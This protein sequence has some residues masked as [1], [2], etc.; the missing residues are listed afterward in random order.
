VQIAAH[1]QAQR[2]I[3][4]REWFIEEED[5]R[6]PEE[7]P[8]KDDSLLLPPGQ[9]GWQAVEEIFEVQQPHNFVQIDRCD[10]PAPGEYEVVP[11]PEMGIQ[12]WPLED[13][14][15]IP[16]VW[17]Q[18][19]HIAAVNADAPGCGCFEPGDESQGRRLAAAGGA[20]D[21]QEFAIGD[22]EIEAIHRHDAAAERPGHIAQR[23]LRHGITP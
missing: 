13:E 1:F 21:G 18:P 12:G 17:R 9:L 8:A 14:G 10:G 5:R 6:P 16:A 7:R 22:V 20:D 23:H 4:V 11:D 2:R 15:D 3:E 19:G